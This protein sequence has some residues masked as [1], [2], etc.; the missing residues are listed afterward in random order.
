[1]KR[2]MNAG[3][4]LLKGKNRVKGEFGLIALT[5]NIK[6]V[7]SIKNGKNGNNNHGNTGNRRLLEEFHVPT[8]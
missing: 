7:I 6:R 2:A 1:M 8:G 5:Y 3:Y 4:I